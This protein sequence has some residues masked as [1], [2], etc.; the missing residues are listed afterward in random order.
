L[1]SLSFQLQR[2]AQDPNYAVARAASRAINELKKQW[3][4]EEGDSLR[5][6]MNQNLASGDTDDDNSVADD[7]SW[8]VNK[9]KDSSF[10]GNGSKHK[11][12]PWA[13]HKHSHFTFRTQNQINVFWNL[14]KWGNSE[15][16]VNRSLLPLDIVHAWSKML[17]LLPYVSLQIKALHKSQAL[18]NPK[19][20]GSRRPYGSL[21]IKANKKEKYRLRQSIQY[22]PL[23]NIKYSSIPNQNAANDI[24]EMHAKVI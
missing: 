3:E 4:L 18:Q 6:V 22:N 15:N 9:K 14:G 7:A 17:Y 12:S 20:R 1:Q 21:Q 19:Q 5:F 2:L 10:S 13:A 16:S 24:T 8:V 11:E 23:S